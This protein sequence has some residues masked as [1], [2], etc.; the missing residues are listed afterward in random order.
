[1]QTV[2]GSLTILNPHA[3]DAKVFWN[4]VEVVVQGISVTNDDT[5]KA[6]VILTVAEDPILAELKAAG[7]VIRRV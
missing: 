1:M 7:I 6:Q 5:T 2:Q 3:P 4:G